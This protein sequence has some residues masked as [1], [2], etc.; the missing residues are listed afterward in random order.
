MVFLVPKKFSTFAVSNSYLTQS[1]NFNS[2]LADGCPVVDLRVG[3]RADE[4][5]A[6][7]HGLGGVCHFARTA[8]VG[9]RAGTCQ[10]VQV[11][12][13]RPAFRRGHRP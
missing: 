3:S 6:R 8:A 13:V 4:L 9:N 10:R 1:E 5:S 7:Q 12:H 2:T 11:A